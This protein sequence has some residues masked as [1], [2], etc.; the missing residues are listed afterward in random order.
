M[1]SITTRPELESALLNALT[2][3]NIWGETEL[4]YYFGDETAL[5][6]DSEFA[7][8]F[9]KEFSG[10]PDQLFWFGP[11]ASVAY[12]S[13]SSVSGLTLTET[14]DTSLADM[15]V[16]SS[17]HSKSKGLEG[18]FHFPG[19]SYREPGDSWQLGVFN[20]ALPALRVPA[21]TGAGQYAAWTV[22]HEIGHSMG[23]K[24]TFVD[25]R[26]NPEDPLPDV[27]KA[28]DNE[29]YSVMSY[30]PAFDGYD[31]G[32][33]V[34]Y[35]ALDVASL[36]ALYGVSDKASGDSTYRLL[37][38]KRGALDLTEGD[39][40]IGR[41]LYCIWDSGGEDTISYAGA[42]RNVMINL[43]A[44][45]LDITGNSES[46]A[47]VISALKD[48]LYF[49]TLSRSIQQDIVNPKHNAGGSWSE[50]LLP[51]KS[52]FV[53]NAGGYSIAHGAMIENATGGMSADLLIG[54]EGDNILIGQNG[55]DTLIGG[56]GNDILRGGR[57]H[58]VLIGGLGADTFVFSGGRDEIRDF[59]AA[60]GDV[61]VGNWPM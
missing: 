7:E 50:L 59:N 41:A 54:N 19:M 4:Q 51:S 32:H 24:H 22:F 44:A 49:D 53:A 52:G 30:T 45:T 26:P 17:T 9:H 46:L 61:L 15:V 18:F 1:A 29:R 25:K 12:A 20:S 11:I 43:N 27:G 14:T 23:L 48:T 28:L 47:R 5:T 58:D 21:E 31:Y 55:R 56:D 40:S 8:A 39:I 60:E 10:R 2:A 42:S 57:G 16:V 6:L 38:A 13:I 34:S 3:K 33:V 35:M 37:D 36:Q